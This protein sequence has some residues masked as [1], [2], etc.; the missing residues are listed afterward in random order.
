MRPHYQQQR[1]KLSSAFKIF[2]MHIIILYCGRLEKI[3]G[4]NFR[5]H[6]CH[7]PYNRKWGGGALCQCWE[8]L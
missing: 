3:H 2:I 6:A 7:F 4:V 5:M 1:G 8:V